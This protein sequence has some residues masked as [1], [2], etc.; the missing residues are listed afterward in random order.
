MIKIEKIIDRVTGEHSAFRAETL[1]L[2]AEQIY[3]KAH[4]IHVTEE[5]A[6]LIIRNTDYYQDDK[7]ILIILNQLTEGKG[8][9]SAFLKWMRSLDSIDVSNVKLAADVLRKFCY[10]SKFQKK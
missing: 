1:R 7:W 8:F 4:I 5:M 10:D 2:P 6:N 9:L 3:R